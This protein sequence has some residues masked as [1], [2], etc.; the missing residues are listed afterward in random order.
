MSGMPFD[1][2]IKKEIKYKIGILEIQRHIPVLYNFIKICNIKET[3]VT[4][5]TTQT[6]YSRLLSYNLDVSEFNFIVKKKNETLIGFLKRVKIICNKIDLLFVNTIH[7]VF[8]DLIRYIN[9]NPK[10]KMILVIHHAN[11][12]IRPHLIFRPLQPLDTIDTILSSALIKG[13]IFPKFVAVN[14]IYKP[15]KKYIFENMNFSRKIFT[16]PSSSFE[17]EFYVNNQDNNDLLKLVLP[18]IIQHH[19]KDYLN[20]IPAIQ[21]ICEEYNERFQVYILGQPIGAYG[22]LVYKKFNELKYKGY[23]IVT[24]K[25]FVPDYKFDEILKL[26]DLILTPLKIKTKADN[27]ISEEYGKTVGSGV[28]YNAIKY[29][30][31][32]IVPSGFNMFDELISSTI[33]YKKPKDIENIIVRLIKNPSELK[34]LKIE[35]LKNSRKFSLK[36]L[37]D[38][39]KNCVL[40]WLDS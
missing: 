36:I 30:R 2:N 16:I 8:F 28:V 27:L 26:S 38:Y 1:V 13:F 7:T 19:R 17:E 31:P 12:W 34:D 40:G 37:Q 18:G 6:I 9:F 25:D 21:N 20:L 4:I 5:F 33:K 29:G 15:I 24:F 22:S 32:I 23:N 35:A 3:D 14:V 39:F 10:T 11:A